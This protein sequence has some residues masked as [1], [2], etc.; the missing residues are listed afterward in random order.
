MER[1]SAQQH[2]IAMTTVWNSTIKCTSSSTFPLSFF[3]FYFCRALLSPLCNFIPIFAIPVFLVACPMSQSQRPLLL[4]LQFI[5][6][7]IHWLASKVCVPIYAGKVHVLKCQHHNAH[8]LLLKV[9]V[10]R[11]CCHCFLFL[12]GIEPFLI[13][14]VIVWLRSFVLQPR[15][16][17]NNKKKKN[18]NK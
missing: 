10:L 15:G 8:C 1:T 16:D 5:H 13:D 7:A 9:F 3:C 14:I 17:A 4:L 6:T 2:I 11:I 12:R 18:E